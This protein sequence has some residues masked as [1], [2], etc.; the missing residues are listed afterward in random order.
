MTDNKPTTTGGG[1]ITRNTQY[2]GRGADNSG[3]G[4]RGGRGRSSNT[5][6]GGG[7][8]NGGG[9]S[10]GNQSALTKKSSHTGQ[11]QS[12]CMK[13]VVISS[14]G[15]RA[16][17]Y[18]ILKDAIPV[19]CAEN[20]YQAVGEIVH[21]MR[22]WDENRFYPS[23]PTDAERLKFSK[24]Y[25][26][27][28]CQE[29]I[30]TP[31]MVSRQVQDVDPDTG[32]PLFDTN[33]DPVMITRQV[34]E[35]VISQA[36]VYGQK[37]VVTDEA[38]QKIVMGKYER[39]VRELEKKWNK[40]QEDKKLVIAMI[41]GQL[42]DDTQAQMILVASYAQARKD[43]DIVTFLKLLRDIC[44]GSD[45]G[46]LSYQP[47]K[48][49]VAIKGVCNFTNSD[50]SNPHVY[51]KELRTKYEAMKAVAGRLPFGTE[52]LVF[53]MQQFIS[54]GGDRNAT[55][56]TFFSM[57]PKERA[58][59]ERI[60]DDLVLAMI[61]LNNSKN[62]DAKKDM[63]RTFAN[64]NKC[65]YQITLEKM[66]RLLS[67]QYPMTK[68]QSKKNTPYDGSRSRRKGGDADDNRDEAT[69]GTPIAGAHTVDDADTKTT[70]KSTPANT[71]GAHISDSEECDP[72]GSSRSVQQ[73][74]ATYAADDPFW[75]GQDN[76]DDYSV[77]TKDSAQ[78]LVGF[79]AHAEEEC[80]EDK[81]ILA[82][83]EEAR[84]MAIDQQRLEALLG[85]DTPVDGSEDLDEEIARVIA[86]EWINTADPDDTSDLLQNMDD[87]DVA[88]LI[89]SNLDG[90]LKGKIPTVSDFRIGQ[91]QN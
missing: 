29:T 42:D 39:K 9:R 26:T 65:A 8:G 89:T 56:D 49:I 77:D 33:D 86:V 1:A 12:G 70:S 30:V 73:L 40:C 90:A 71:A 14:E 10:R 44:N 91:H 61:F 17:Q 62:D 80:E 81:D 46:G 78:D 6:R 53:A 66:A 35:D 38:M 37:W 24:P 4:G 21:D 82:L 79:H 18:K 43:G 85:P 45:D 88:V 28:L 72:S 41:W 5:G 83:E 25:N 47:F 59:W 67:S 2:S 57:T 27:V 20:N 11:I 36:P 19:F 32:D 16:T 58:K 13:S 48:A 51:K 74:L 52:T 22:D 64:G 15:N 31:T 69:S 68:G 75:G 23:A 3:R 63:R 60:N 87:L 84:L 76:T 54:L 7:R 50:V 34:E 55:L